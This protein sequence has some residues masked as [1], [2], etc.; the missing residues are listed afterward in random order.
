[1]LVFYTKLENYAQ[2]PGFFKINQPQY[3]IQK[4]KTKKHY[5]TPLFYLFKVNLMLPNFFLGKFIFSKP[6]STFINKSSPFLWAISQQFIVLRKYTFDISMMKSVHIMQCI[7][8]IQYMLNINQ[9]TLLF[10]WL[11]V[12]LQMF[13]IIE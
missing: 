2:G 1:M 13:D 12:A 4:T 11:L 5:K 3:C 9:S 7:N 10:Q 6:A 8:P